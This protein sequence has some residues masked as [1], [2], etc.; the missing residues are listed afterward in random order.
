MWRTVNGPRKRIKN[1]G[2]IRADYEEGDSTS[3]EGPEPGPGNYLKN[4]HVSE[5]GQMKV[6]HNH[7]EQFGKLEERF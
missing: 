2:S 6:F 1:R 5:F 3:E 4:H 7:P